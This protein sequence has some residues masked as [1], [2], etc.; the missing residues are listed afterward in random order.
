MEIVKKILQ[1][2]T[3]DIKCDSCGD[4]CRVYIH[5][6]DETLPPEFEYMELQATWGYNTNKDR[7][8]W[9]AQLCEKCVDEK[10]S[11]IGF[12]KITYMI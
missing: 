9:T 1:D 3:V 8:R 5:D 12:R 10:L 4:S 7:E 2:A 11:F 6:I